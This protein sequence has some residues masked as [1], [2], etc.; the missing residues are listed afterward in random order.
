MW[1][2]LWTSLKTIMS[3][4]CQVS[5]VLCKYFQYNL[6]NHPVE[7]VLLPKWQRL[8]AYTQ[9]FLLSQLFLFRYLMAICLGKLHPSLAPESAFWLV[10]KKIVIPFP[11][12]SDWLKGGYLTKPK[13]P[14][15]NS[16]RVLGKV[17]FTNT[18]RHMGG[19]ALFFSKTVSVC[20]AWNCS[21]QFNDM[22]R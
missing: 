16:R 3:T 7:Q 1:K 13:G 6:Y 20:N 19:S 14:K 12:A 8:L 11:F 18:E 4:M 21:H 15:E 17:S 2:N 5:L 9:I 22:K 10:E